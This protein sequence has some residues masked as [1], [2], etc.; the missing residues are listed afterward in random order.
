RKWLNDHSAKIDCKPLHD[1]VGLEDVLRHV[2]EMRDNDTYFFT[3]KGRLTVVVGGNLLYPSCS[4][5]SLKTQPERDVWRC[6]RCQRD[7]KEPYYRYLLSVEVRYGSAHVEMKV[8]D[9]VGLGLFGMNA[10]DLLSLK[11]I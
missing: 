10:N 11:V 9:A 1:F 2:R 7:M 8:F 5:C 6:R 4:G 3:T